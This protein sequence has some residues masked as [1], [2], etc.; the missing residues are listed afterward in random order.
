MSPHFIYL[1][2]V[3]HFIKLNHVN[4]YVELRKIPSSLSK[5]RSSISLVNDMVPSFVRVPSTYSKGV[6]LEGIGIFIRKFT[7]RKQRKVQ[8]KN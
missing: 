2:I 6:E 7:L 4:Y 8:H 3:Y 5:Q 1:S